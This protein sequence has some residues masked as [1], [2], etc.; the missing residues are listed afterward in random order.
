MAKLIVSQN[1]FTDSSLTF[2]SSSHPF[3]TPNGKNLGC[4]PTLYGQD[5][6]A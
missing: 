2:D 3:F 4:L 6:V 5:V 1:V